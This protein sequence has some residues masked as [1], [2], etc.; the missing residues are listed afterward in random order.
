VASLK[1]KTAQPEENIS[2]I[3]SFIN[4]IDNKGVISDEELTHF[5]RELEKFYEFA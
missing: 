5:H 2:N 3:V 1:R 4:E